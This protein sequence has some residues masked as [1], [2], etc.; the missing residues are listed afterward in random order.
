L[1]FDGVGQ[2]DTA[3]VSDIRIR[4]RPHN[5][6]VRPL[7]FRPARGM[8]ETEGGGYGG[9]HRLPGRHGASKIGS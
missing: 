8:S 4:R 6:R 2:V 5:L 3:S 1:F 9:T 7:P